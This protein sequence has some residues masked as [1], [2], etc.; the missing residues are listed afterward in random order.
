VSIGSVKS[1]DFI[2]TYGVFLL[3]INDF[4]HCSNL[5]EFHIFADDTNLF[6]SNSNLFALQS[7][8]NE[9]VCHVSNWLV[10]NKL[11]IDKLTLLYFTLHKTK[12]KLHNQI[13]Y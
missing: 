3:H 4:S 6:C 5:F 8:V 1:D 7:L 10:A 11:N 12:Y 9:N 13:I 2:I